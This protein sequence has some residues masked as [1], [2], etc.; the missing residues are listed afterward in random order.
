MIFSISLNSF[1]LHTNTQIRKLWCTEFPFLKTLINTRGNW[2]NIIASKEMQ[3][4]CRQTL[5]TESE[6]KSI[7]FICSPNLLPLS[8]YAN[9]NSISPLLALKSFD[10][11]F[12]NMLVAHS[13]WFLETQYITSILN[14]LTFFLG[15]APYLLLGTKQSCALLEAASLLSLVQWIKMSKAGEI[16]PFSISVV[17][18]WECTTILIMCWILI[19]DLGEKI[20]AFV[21]RRMVCIIVEYCKEKVE[22][23]FELEVKN[24]YMYIIYLCKSIFM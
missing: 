3:W 22:I 4:Y 15:R 24:L 18:K 2:P 6:T 23:I 20:I 16:I 12:G 11:A 9:I 8:N 14:P 13:L 21:K 10:K 19:K 5:D 7:T 1:T 17:L